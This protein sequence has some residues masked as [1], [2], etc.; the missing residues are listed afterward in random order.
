MERLNPFD[1]GKQ[2]LE[3]IPGF[4]DLIQEMPSSFK[5]LARVMRQG[6]FR[7]EADLP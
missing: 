7:V 1:L 5:Q 2:V 3:E 6:K 4:I